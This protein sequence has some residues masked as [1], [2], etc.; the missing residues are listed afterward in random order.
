MHDDYD[1]RQEQLNKYSLMSSKAFMEKLLEMFK[2]H[3][4]CY[5]SN[6]EVLYFCYKQW[7]NLIKLQKGA[8]VHVFPLFIVYALEKM[9]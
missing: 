1:L 5:F 8:V 4:V 9:P 2:G 3:V 7:K 6:L